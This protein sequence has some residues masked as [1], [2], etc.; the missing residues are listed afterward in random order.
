[1]KMF[2][3]DV[4]SGMILSSS[5]KRKIFFISGERSSGIENVVMK[6]YIWCKHHKKVKHQNIQQFEPQPMYRL[7]TISN[8]KLN[9]GHYK[10]SLLVR[11]TVPQGSIKRHYLPSAYYM[12]YM[13]LLLTIYIFCL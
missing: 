6:T 2:C 8:V 5:Y 11:P 10:S 4:G 7:E 12:K 9:W 13:N 3:V 1:M